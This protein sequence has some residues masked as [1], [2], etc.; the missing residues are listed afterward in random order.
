MAEFDDGLQEGQCPGPGF[1]QQKCSNQLYKNHQKFIIGVKLGLNYVKEIL[2]RGR[3][4]FPFGP[5]IHPPD[6]GQ[7]FPNC[8]T[9][10]GRPSSSL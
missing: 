7:P 6:P 3:N 1:L 10:A 8:R 4:P 2:E 5:I 9:G